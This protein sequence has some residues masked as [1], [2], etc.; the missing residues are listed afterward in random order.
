MEGS[1]SSPLLLSIT[2]KLVNECVTVS[3]RVREKYTRKK[4]QHK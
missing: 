3:E 2:L 4:T 1:E